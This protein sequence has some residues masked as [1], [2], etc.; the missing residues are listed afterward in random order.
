MS[1]EYK[2]TDTYT[3]QG[4]HVRVTRENLTKLKAK[5]GNRWGMFSLAVRL[6]RDDLNEGR[7]ISVT[8]RGRNLR[9]CLK[10]YAG[11]ADK[12]V[13]SY[14]APSQPTG[15]KKKA[16][17]KESP[18]A[19]KQARCLYLPGVKPAPEEPSN[20]FESSDSGESTGSIKPE[21]SPAN[22]YVEDLD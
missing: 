1:V 4:E 3:A 13:Q 20:N 11:D 10:D 17:A 14:T 2:V 7:D 6:L 8:I 12:V 15:H 16:E 9:E 19:K 18:K 22:Y 21:Y 5:F